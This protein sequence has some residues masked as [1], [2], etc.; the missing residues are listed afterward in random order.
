MLA[1]SNKERLE[2]EIANL[3]LF[4]SK[5]RE[6]FFEKTSNDINSSD[7]LM[8]HFEIMGLFQSDE[9]L[10]QLDLNIQL[11][12]IKLASYYDLLSKDRGN[13]NVQRNM[14]AHHNNDLIFHGRV[15]YNFLLYKATKNF[16]KVQYLVYSEDAKPEEESTVKTI[17]LDLDN[18]VNEFISLWSNSKKNRE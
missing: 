8:N 10:I 17:D 16:K 11:F 5:G 15:K 7:D 9:N 3:I 2:Q 13:I 14:F 18:D 6:Y 12:Y 1:G 4:I